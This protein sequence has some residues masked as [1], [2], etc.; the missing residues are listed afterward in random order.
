MSGLGSGD[1]PDPPELK[2]LKGGWNQK[3]VDIAQKM[4]NA[5]PVPRPRCPQRVADYDPDAKKY[6]KEVCDVIEQAGIPFAAVSFHLGLFVEAYCE[7]RAALRENFE[8][9][10]HCTEEIV[11]KDGSTGI[12]PSPILSEVRRH[13]EHLM[14]LAKELAITPSSRS[15]ILRQMINAAYEH[16]SDKYSSLALPARPRF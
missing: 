2:I 10:K 16:D 15:V 8:N 3:K 14:R 12:K 7:Y 1:I 6:W 13:R 11:Y 9:D 5:K 4:L